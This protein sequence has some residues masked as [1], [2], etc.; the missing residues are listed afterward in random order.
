MKQYVDMLMATYGGTVAECLALLPHSKKV[1]GSIPIQGRAFLCGV[2]IFS[3]CRRKFPSGTPVCP[4]LV[5]I[6][7]KEQVRITPSDM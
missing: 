4:L 5:D 6:L 1:L 2:C 7:K 3:P